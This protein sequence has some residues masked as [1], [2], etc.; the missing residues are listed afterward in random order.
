LVY[1]VISTQHD[2]LINGLAGVARSRIEFTTYAATRAG[3][4]AIAEAIRTCGLVGHTGAMGTMQIL[5][6]MIDGGN[7]TL[8]ELPTDGGQEHR[9]LTIFDYQIA[10]SESK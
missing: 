3:A 1:S 6:V 4:N 2:H 5:S 8:D 7:Q 9:Y 10:Y